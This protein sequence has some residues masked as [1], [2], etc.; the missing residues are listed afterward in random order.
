MV[1]DLSRLYILRKD[2]VIEK[3]RHANDGHALQ[4]SSQVWG[5][6]LPLLQ[7]YLWSI[8]STS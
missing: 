4:K 1:G 2:I 5:A 6:A 7:C 3:S 8:V